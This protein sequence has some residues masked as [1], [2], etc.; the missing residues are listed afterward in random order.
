MNI[1]EIKAR[2]QAATPGDWYVVPNDDGNYSVFTDEDGTPYK[3]GE[4]YL[5]HD[6]EVATN[7]R[8][9]IPELIA[10]VERLTAENERDE[11]LIESYKESNLEQAAENYELE[12]ENDR[13]KESMKKK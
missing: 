11:K 2:E 6:A 9:D 8:T 7:A 3:V 5:R 1:E 12:N 4:A 10:E 13:L